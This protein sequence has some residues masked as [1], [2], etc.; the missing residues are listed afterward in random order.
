MGCWLVS[1]TYVKQLC[2]KHM[3]QDQAE[4]DVESSQCHTEDTMVI[5]AST[6]SAREAAFSRKLSQL[7]ELAHGST[8]TVMP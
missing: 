1:Y 5:A 3:K 6:G 7:S 4:Q 2:A 8:H